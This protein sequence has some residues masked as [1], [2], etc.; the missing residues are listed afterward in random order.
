M[1]T[2]DYTVKLLDVTA[3]NLGVPLGSFL[4]KHERKIIDS[5]PS[6]TQ[7][8]HVIGRLR[9]LATSDLHMQLRGFDYYRDRQTLTSGMTRIATLIREIR[10][11]AKAAGDLVI[12]LDNGDSLQGTP[13]DDLAIREL[14]SPHIFYRALELMS[15]D[16]AGL[17]NHDFNFDLAHLIDSVREARV[18]VVCANARRVDG[19]GLP[20]S[21][22]VVLNRNLAGQ[23]LRV[24]VFSILPP[25][26]LIWDAD[27]LSGRIVFDDMTEAA[28]T[29]IS[30]L[31]AQRCDIIVALAHTGLGERSERTGQE[32]ALWPLSTLEGL[33]AIVAGHT[34]LHLP[35]PKAPE[36]S[37][38][39]RG[40]LNG[41]PV[42]MPGAGADHLGVIDLE[43]ARKDMRW[44]I[45]GAK[46][47][48]RSATVQEDQELSDMTAPIH[49]AT[50]K[51]LSQVIGHTSVALHSYFGAFGTS[52]ALGL[53]AAAKQEAI[54]Q[55]GVVPDGVPLLSSVPPAKMGGRGGPENYVDIPAG[56]LSLRHVFDL[57]TF[58]NR[59]AAVLVTGAQ[60]ADWIEMSAGLYSQITPGVCGQ[61]ILDA[62]RPAHGSD[63]FFG[64]EYV[65]D[66]SVPAR[67]DANGDLANPSSRRLVSLRYQKRSVA[68]SDR[69]A[70]ALSSYRANGGG[71]V[72]ALE[73]AT[74]LKLPSLSVREAL[75]TYI[76]SDNFP[77]WAQH[78]GRFKSLG[79]TEVVLGTGP[80]A[81]SHL[82]DL[83]DVFSGS[84]G[85]DEDGFLCLRLR[86]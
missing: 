66:L 81:E 23:P 49:D 20:V 29:A 65:L 55:L 68:P 85:L 79:G 56:A 30:D 33:H 64:I 32:N 9:I 37:E 11:E 45:A 13:L 35:D 75:Q 36:N 7:S 41:K 67:F 59:L 14:D 43:L 84:N 47:A 70:I 46:A 50:R 63:L 86:L 2:L 72:R 27:H 73:A 12:T 71:H 69:F 62:A 19:G 26:T 4:V 52:S 10:A 1:S 83:G 22:W 8:G 74:P 61:M 15:Y 76:K 25:Q 44:F 82:Q 17:G 18:P 48:L 51:H 54:N 34:H 24:G 57:C 5:K 3:C 42:V 78:H 40:I 38:T 58:P 60:L 6:V 80:R 53:I 28:R 16:A 39:A 31:Q 21:P 77:H